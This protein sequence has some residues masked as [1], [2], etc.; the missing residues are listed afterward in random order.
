VHVAPA[1]GDVPDPVQT[2]PQVL[3]DGRRS[4][5]GVQVDAPGIDQSG[6]RLLEHRD[7]ELGDGVLEG[8]GVGPQ[9]S[10]QYVGQRVVGADLGPGPPL[11]AGATAFGREGEP[12][13]GVPAETQGEAEA[14]DARQRRAAAGRQFADG[15]RRDRRRIPEN[16][17]R[18]QRL[19]RRQRR[20]QPPDPRFQA[21]GR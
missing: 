5:H 16:L 6:D 9:Q 11:P 19:R 14:G 10:P 2:Q 21:G 17:L 1:A 13:L 20:Q 7:V 18:D 8:L 3:G 12:E 4:A 15:G